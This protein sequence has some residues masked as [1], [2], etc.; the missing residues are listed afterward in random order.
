[1]THQLNKKE[2]ERQYAR[3]QRQEHYDHIQ[4]LYQNWASRENY[5]KA[6]AE[7]QHLKQNGVSKEDLRKRTSGNC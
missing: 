4:W 1:M 5:G 2:A 7:V 6:L 3:R